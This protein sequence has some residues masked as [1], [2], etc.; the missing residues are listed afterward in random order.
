MPAPPGL[1]DAVSEYRGVFDLWDTTCIAAVEGYS[2]FADSIH[3]IPGN[4][5]IA[6]SDADDCSC[7]STGEIFD[8]GLEHLDVPR[9]TCLIATQDPDRGV[10]SI[11]KALEDLEIGYVNRADSYAPGGGHAK[12][13]EV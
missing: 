6:A 9:L 8:R 7:T 12:E 5:D 1:R 4:H 2:F 10:A 13:M 11:H 3:D